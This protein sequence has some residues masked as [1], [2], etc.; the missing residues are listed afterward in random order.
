MTSSFMAPAPITFQDLSEFEKKIPPN[1]LAKNS[2]KPVPPAQTFP[3]NNSVKPVP[4]A[5]TFPVNKLARDNS[6]VANPINKP[7]T[8]PLPKQLPQATPIPPAPT[9]TPGAPAIG[10]PGDPGVIYLGGGM[11]GD[12]FYYSRSPEEQ[13]YIQS[14]LRANPGKLVP[15]LFKNGQ[16]IGAGAPINTLPVSGGT[17]KDPYA[18]IDELPTFNSDPTQ[19]G[20][21]GG[22]GQVGAPFDINTID[23]ADIPGV[24]K[25]RGQIGLP[26]YQQL[27]DFG[28]TEENL[29]NVLKDLP[30][31]A[32]TAELNRYMR[33][34]AMGILNT[35][36]PFNFDT[37]DHKS[38]DQMLA[39]RGTLNQAGY[40]QLV[41]Y[42]HP[43]TLLRMAIRDGGVETGPNL[44]QYFNQN[45]MGILA[46]REFERDGGFKY[47]EDQPGLGDN[48]GFDQMNFNQLESATKAAPFA[49]DSNK[50]LKPGYSFTPG[51]GKV[52]LSSSPFEGE[53]DEFGAGTIN[54]Y[55]PANPVSVSA[56]SGPIDQTGNNTVGETPSTPSDTGNT[57]GTGGTGDTG[58]T[59]NT[60]GTGGTGGGGDSGTSVDTPNSGSGGVVNPVG[61]APGGPTG[62]YEGTGVGSSDQMAAL[63]NLLAIGQNNNSDQIAGVLNAITDLAT[64]NPFDDLPPYVAPEAPV[65]N[66]PTFKSPTY[67]FTI[68]TPSTPEPGPSF[69][70][71]GAQATSV[72]GVKI[73]RSLAQKQLM[74]QLGTGFFN[75][76]TN[77][78]LR[79][80]NINV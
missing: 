29:R 18:A 3:V 37:L 26:G 43:E 41:E 56:S 67:N 63:L 65:Y 15:D 80:S 69:Q 25:E 30:D 73:K 13:D 68:P 45:P 75:R 31:V 52:L 53:V 54:V 48:R 9:P 46:Q 8:T 38:I 70:M 50:F 40:N 39:N 77:P 7:S 16:L 74:T 44:T 5:R 57:G 71:F 24:L 59:G 11:M 6:Q 28:H 72:P 10:T 23:H 2:F 34:N 4:L 61:P 49:F 20:T 42:G 76:S 64:A 12:P 58:G 36:G 14:V 47:P 19:P 55:G 51:P 33:N 21:G 60:G 1:L 78:T 62:E 79:I 17:Q 32:R 22:G 27:V 35:K 66:A